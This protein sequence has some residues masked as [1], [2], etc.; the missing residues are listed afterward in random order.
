ME[1]D[2]EDLF[3]ISKFG[4]FWNFCNENLGKTSHGNYRHTK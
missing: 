2:R 3:K 4:N 1:M